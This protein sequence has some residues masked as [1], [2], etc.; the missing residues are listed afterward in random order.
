MDVEIP[1]VSTENRAPSKV[2]NNNN[3]N[4]SNEGKEVVKSR[5]G[6]HDSK[7]PEEVVSWEALEKF[8]ISNGFVEIDNG[9]SNSAT[10]EKGKQV[11][12]GSGSVCKCGQMAPTIRNAIAATGMRGSSISQAMRSL[13]SGGRVGATNI[14]ATGG[15]SHC[16]VT[17]IPCDDCCVGNTVRTTY[18]IEQLGAD[19]K[20]HDILR[21]SGGQGTINKLIP[22]ETYKFRIY[23]INQ[24]NTHGPRSEE[25]ILH[26]PFESPAAPCIA[27]ADCC[28]GTPRALITA[29][30][31]TLKWKERHAGKRVSNRDKSFVKK[32]LAEWAGIPSEHSNYLSTAELET[33]FNKFDRYIT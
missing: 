33:A 26:M 16:C 31:I 11:W 12:K 6:S 1:S 8:F 3:N 21:T 5:N 27:L 30:S 19:G 22:G 13:R 18:T 14:Y 15:G 20:Y 4:N 17:I 7:D 28:S 9:N 24:D 32:M 2:N 25:I 10:G 29:R 23:G